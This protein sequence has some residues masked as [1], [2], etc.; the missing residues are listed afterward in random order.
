MHVLACVI[1]G[2]E[3][4]LS[5]VES[6]KKSVED[7]CATCN[8]T[9]SLTCFICSYTHLDLKSKVQHAKQWHKNHCF[10]CQ[11]LFQSQE[12]AASHT[13]KCIETA[14]E[15][16]KSLYA[17]ILFA[18]GNK[19]ATLSCE[20][21]TVQVL[22]Y[23]EFSSHVVENHSYKVCELC[24]GVASNSLALRK[25]FLSQHVLILMCLHCEHKFSSLES[26]ANHCEM[27][28]PNVCVYCQKTCRDE[29]LIT[30]HAIECWKRLPKSVRRHF[31]E[32]P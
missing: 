31:P 8:S 27:E 18:L 16:D 26:R 28:H 12:A 3:F 30:D 6:E 2:T 9:L 13:L 23:E 22:S 4:A 32:P 1:C 17:K 7:A 14:K 5:S 15:P 21:C 25:H 11:R 10:I 29:L 19:D 24:S 20:K